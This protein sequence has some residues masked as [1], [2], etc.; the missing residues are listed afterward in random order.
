ME[1]YV[2]SYHI[3]FWILFYAV[4][5]WC[6]SAHLPDQTISFRNVDC[7]ET[8]CTLHMCMDTIL[9]IAV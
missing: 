5:Y 4:V 2:H 7:E 8:A 3:D 1:F 9:F 6:I